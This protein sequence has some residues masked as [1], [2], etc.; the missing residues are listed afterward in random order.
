MFLKSPLLYESVSNLFVGTGIFLQTRKPVF[1]QNPYTSQLKTFLSVGVASDNFSN[2]SQH[3]CR[4]QKPVSTS[5]PVDFRA[6]PSYKSISYFPQGRLMTPV[7]FS[8]VGPQTPGEVLHLQFPANYSKI[9]PTKAT[10]R[11]RNDT[12]WLILSR[13]PDFKISQKSISLLWMWL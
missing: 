7:A 4:Q 11:V 5:N 9:F 2:F 6:G 3:C 10:N 8:I 12:Y 13:F 1:F